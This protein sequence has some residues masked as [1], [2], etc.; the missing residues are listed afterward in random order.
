MPSASVKP[1]NQG[2]SDALDP[3][4][5]VINLVEKKTRNL[6]KRRSKLEQYRVDLQ[7][8]KQLNDDQQQ[9]VA[10][11]DRVLGNLEVVRELN[12]QFGV[13]LAEHNKFMKKQAKREQIERQQEE[14]SKVKEILKFQEVLQQL[15]QEEVR[16]DFLAGT[17]GAVQVS[18]EVL[19]SLQVL[20]KLT[21]T[22]RTKGQSIS[23]MQGEFRSAAEHMVLLR[24]G[25]NKDVAGNTYKA[26]LSV[27]EEISNCPY[28]ERKPAVPE[29]EEEVEEEEEEQEAHSTTEPEEVVPEYTNGLVGEEEEEVTGATELVITSPVTEGPPPGLAPP[30]AGPLLSPALPQEPAGVTQAQ[31]A[32][33]AAMAQMS[34]SGVPGTSQVAAA[35]A[36]AAAGMPPAPSYFT[37]APPP[38]VPQTQPPQQTPAQPPQQPQAPQQPPQQPPQPQPQPPQQTPLQP[39]PPPPQ[40]QPISL[41]DLVAPGSFDFLQ[42]SQVAQEPPTVYMDPAVVSIGSIKT[43][44]VTQRSV[45]PVPQP[46][47]QV[48]PLVPPSQDPTHPSN[49]PTQTFT[50]QTYNVA[51]YSQ[52]MPV[53]PSSTVVD[54][55]PNPPPPI[56]LP[57]QARPQ[58]KVEFNP[59]ASPWTG[60][61]V[62]PPQPS[63]PLANVQQPPPSQPPQQ[64]AQDDDWGAQ[65]V[66]MNGG[67]DKWGSVEGT[68]WGDYDEVQGG[69]GPHNGHSDYERRGGFRSRGRGFGRGNFRGGRGNFQ[70][71]R[72]GYGGYGGFRGGRGGMGG[73][74]RGG[75][76]GFRGQG[77]RGNFRGRGGPGG[78][79]GYQGPRQ[80]YQQ[81]Q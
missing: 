74:P 44:S 64:Q 45:S 58:D 57:P 53:Y 36:V 15:G 56:P 30:P 60:Q 2:P 76:G 12:Q 55:T 77:M 51:S 19:D 71:G 79:G 67:E 1:E 62:P 73:G 68:N 28:P 26:L 69:G 42:E 35:A 13:I 16:A 5:K 27:M 41:N 11:Y 63:A 6:E 21:T 25:K 81:Q 80:G 39:P 52:G 18:A 54:S 3:F 46:P 49:I 78:G 24:E 7:A 33:V 22:S 20:Q 47:Q 50:N 61:Q 10:N 32:L 48:S 38:P 8:G 34:S 65:E 14:I 37:Q 23:E 4:H 40:L 43:E 66:P 75:R 9:A 59:E 31:E 72:G 17:N 29:E 70:N